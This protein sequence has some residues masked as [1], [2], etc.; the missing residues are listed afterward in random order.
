MVLTYFYGQHTITLVLINYSIKAQ[1]ESNHLKFSLSCQA[2]MEQDSEKK[3]QVVQYF[4][5]EHF[6]ATVT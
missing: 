1:F 2:S 3:Y 6:D 5:F 4:P